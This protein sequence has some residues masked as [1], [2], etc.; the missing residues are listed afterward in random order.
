MWKLAKCV[1]LTALRLTWREN[2]SLDYS[3]G[4]TLERDYVPLL[5]GRIRLTAT[6]PQVNRVIA[7]RL[8]GVKS[9]GH[10]ERGQYNIRIRNIKRAPIE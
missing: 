9:E 8:M 4:S 1:R 10:R 5:I 2:I 6:P 7:I 3:R